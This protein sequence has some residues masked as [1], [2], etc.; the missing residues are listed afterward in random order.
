[1]LIEDKKPAPRQG[2]RFNETETRVQRTFS[3]NAGYTQGGAKNTA[4]FNLRLYGPGELKGK[5]EVFSTR[6]GVLK[7]KEFVIGSD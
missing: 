3:K 5:A 1:M 6:G 2:N 7:D 4:V